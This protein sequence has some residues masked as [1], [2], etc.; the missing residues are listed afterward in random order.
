MQSFKITQP[1]ESLPSPPHNIH[2]TMAIWH[3][4]FELDL[5]S[6]PLPSHSPSLFDTYNL[7]DIEWYTPQP[8]PA[9]SSP[10]NNPPA[11]LKKAPK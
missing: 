10:H 3:D 1:P 5:S 11:P 6:I 9:S 7:D 2:E 8:P 4:N